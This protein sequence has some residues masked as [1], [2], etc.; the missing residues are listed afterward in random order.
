[1]LKTFMARTDEH[2]TLEARAAAL[3]GGGARA[4]IALLVLASFLLAPLAQKAVLTPSAAEP[5]IAQVVSTPSKAKTNCPKKGLPGQPSACAASSVPLA[6]LGGSASAAMPTAQR[7][8]IAPAYDVSLVT[9]YRGAPPDRPP[10][11]AV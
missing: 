3:L 8:L 9:Q 11:F 2:R 5:L 10:R 7:S 6:D 4:F 1:M